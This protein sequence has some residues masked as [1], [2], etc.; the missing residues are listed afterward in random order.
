[1]QWLT[2][3]SPD[4]SVAPSLG[5]ELDLGAHPVGGGHQHRRAHRAQ[6][7][8]GVVQPA[9]GA[10]AGQHFRPVGGFH[11]RLH[12]LHG[13]VAGSMFTPAAA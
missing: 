1:M 12:H 3:S 13:A 10:D 4:G 9:E 2:I 11:R 8:A 7:L 6:Q 5:G